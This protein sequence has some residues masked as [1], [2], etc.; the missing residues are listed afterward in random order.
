MDDIHAFEDYGDLTGAKSEKDTVVQIV[1]S[2]VIGLGAFFAFCVRHMTS[3]QN[4]RLMLERRF[5]EHDG[6]A[7]MRRAKNISM[8]LLLCLSYLTLSLAGY[9]HYGVSLSSKFLHLQV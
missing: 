5:F 3:N 7:C 6:Q 8:K 2:V 1:L 4:Q 9:R